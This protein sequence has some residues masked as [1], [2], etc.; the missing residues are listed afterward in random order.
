[1]ET[2]LNEMKSAKGGYSKKALEY[3][4]NPK[5]VGEIKNPDGIGRVGNPVCGDVMHIYI[6]VKDN[7]ITDIK[8]KTFG[9]VAA[10]SSSEALCKIAKGKT[11]EQALKITNRDIL[12]HLGWLPP[13]KVHCSVL[14]AEGL[15]DAIVDYRKNQKQK[16]VQKTAKI[17]N[18]NKKSRKA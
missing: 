7:K 16:A 17:K 9:C 5:F 18:P 13:V 1:M 14:G 4:K 2:G 12:N 6:K 10:I 15:R 3:F 8:F 11:L